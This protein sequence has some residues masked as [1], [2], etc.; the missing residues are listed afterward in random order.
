MKNTS[1]CPEWLCRVR[2]GIVAVRAK[3]AAMRREGQREIRRGLEKVEQADRLDRDVQY[4]DRV[5]N[6]EFPAECRNDEIVTVSGGWL[7]NRFVDLE[8]RLEVASSSALKGGEVGEQQHAYFIRAVNSTENSSGSAVYLGALIENRI[9]ALA[10]EYSP[11]YSD[12]PPERISDR[13]VLLERLLT[14][15][16]PYGGKFVSM[17]QGSE[18]AL[19]RD[20]P[21]SCSQAAHSMRDCLQQLIEYL[22]PPDAVRAQPWFQPVAGPPDGVSRLQRFRFILYGSGENLDEATLTSLDETAEI[23]KNALDLCIARAHEHDPTLTHEETQLAID[24]AR[25][26]LNSV[27]QAVQDGPRSLPPK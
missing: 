3:I 7:A 12:Y 18:E 17:L 16:A 19:S 6:V 24:H 4:L 8:T 27:L 25:H 2:S 14:R 21:D 1:G 22:A 15:I 20:D 5:F 10:P 26:A 9:H 13:H 23:A 11:F